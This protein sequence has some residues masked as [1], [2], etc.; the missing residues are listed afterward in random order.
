M[1]LYNMLFGEN[2]DTPVLLGMLKT[3]KAFFARF[4]DI[5]LCNEGKTIR[6]YTRLGGG[7][8]R[9][10]KKEWKE[11]RKHPYYI[12]DFDDS[13]DETYAY[14]DFKVPQDFEY[15]AKKMFKEEPIFVGDRFNKE[16]EEMSVEDSAASQRAEE[17]AKMIMGAIE[18]GNNIIEL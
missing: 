16:V 1:S 6:V 10:Y 9:D 11:I 13:F 2:E 18:S 7:N 4:R 3:N 5:Y 8:R 14:V 15:T 17:I 12:K